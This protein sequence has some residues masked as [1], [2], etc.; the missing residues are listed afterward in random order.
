MIWGEALRK[1]KKERKEGD[2]VLMFIVNWSVTKEGMQ[3]FFP[4]FIKISKK[5]SIN[6]P[7]YHILVCK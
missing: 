5:Y 1:K 4:I 2:D 7:N 3:R 6:I